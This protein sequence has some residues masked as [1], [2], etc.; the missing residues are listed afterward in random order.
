MSA[1]DMD[2]GKGHLGDEFEEIREQVRHIYVC[3]VVVIIVVVNSLYVHCW[4]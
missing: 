2:T 4:M 1:S 3:D